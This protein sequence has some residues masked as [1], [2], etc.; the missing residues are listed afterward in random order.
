MKLKKYNEI[1]KNLDGDGYD[2]KHNP[3]DDEQKGSTD[4]DDI[5]AQK[6]RWVANG[7]FDYGADSEDTEF[8]NVED[9]FDDEDAIMETLLYQIRKMINNTGMKD[10]FVYNNKYDI[11]IEFI[12]NKTEKIGKIMQILSF[13]KKVS[14][15]I[16]IQ[17]DSELELW[18]T[19]EDK[20]LIAIDFY[21][22]NDKKGSDEP[23]PF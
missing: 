1:N 10:Y 3:Y 14:T 4:K 8:E 23:S 19:S 5:S 16:L 11:T 12:M 6:A 2:D 18:E 9:E 20:P 22:E 13:L 17:Y 15:D 7:G 21:Y